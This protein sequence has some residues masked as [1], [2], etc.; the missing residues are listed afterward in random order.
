MKRL[1]G[2][3]ATAH[4]NIEEAV[5]IENNTKNLSSY[6]RILE[7]FYGFYKPIEDILYSSKL[8]EESFLQMP[9]RRKTQWLIN[10]LEHLGFSTSQITKLS[11]C[12][13]LPTLQTQ[14]QLMGCLY[15]LEGSTLGGQI[16]S[17]HLHRNLGI[18][19][20]NGGQFFNSYGTKVGLMWRQFMAVLSRYATASCYEA[21]IIAAAN[22]T[23][24]CFQGWIK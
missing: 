21:E 2:E 9:R 23:F 4:Q 5:N 13:V 3:T 6:I 12:K 14:H 24:S 18:T 22:E 7:L 17:G 19:S 16:I 20:T 8:I 15:V 10:D 1:R 11:L